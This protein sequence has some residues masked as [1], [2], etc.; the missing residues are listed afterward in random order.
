[1][2]PIGDLGQLEPDVER[3]RTHVHCAAGDFTTTI[4]L[5]GRGIEHD[6]RARERRPRE[7]DERRSDDR[8]RSHHAAPPG[9]ARPAIR[10]PLPVSSARAP[11]HGP[12]RRGDRGPGTRLWKNAIAPREVLM[13][14][15]LDG[16]RVLEFAEHGFVPSAGTALA[17]WGAE[18]IKIEHPGR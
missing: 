6:L 12:Q 2:R 10:K 5:R 17:D 8:S 1:G 3:L 9:D 11:T 13:L 15:I 18:V 16:V 7:E 4:L 14:Q